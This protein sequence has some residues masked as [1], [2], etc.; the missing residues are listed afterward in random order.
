MRTVLTLTVWLTSWMERLC[1]WSPCF[2]CSVYSYSDLYAALIRLNNITWYT[3]DTTHFS[4]LYFSWNTLVIGHINLTACLSCDTTTRVRAVFLSRQPCLDCLRWCVL[5][6]SADNLSA[7]K[8]SGQIVQ[9]ASSDTPVDQVVTTCDMWYQLIPRRSRWPRGLSRGSGAACLLG[10]WV[11][12]S[13]VC[14]QVEMSA[15][16]WSLVQRSP[17]ERGVS[18]WS[19]NLDNEEA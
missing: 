13:V 14:C 5:Y 11:L 2:R 19:R 1:H 7:D 6:V 3:Q 10:L 9:L 18:G 16:A 12:V 4:P 17:S 8:H 15:T